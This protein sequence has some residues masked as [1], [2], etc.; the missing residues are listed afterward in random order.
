VFDYAV[1]AVLVVKRDRQQH[2]VYYVSHV[3]TGPELRYFLVEKFAYAL[4]IASCKLRPYFKSHH[5]TILTDQPLWS[6]LEKY[7]NSGRMVKWAIELAPYEISYELRRAI[8]AQALADFIAECSS[9]YHEN[10]Q[11]EEPAA[12]WMLYVDGSFISGGSGAGLIVV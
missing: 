2:L 7:G 4:L 5:I 8:K 6:T 11:I 3:L 10:D 1:S 12:A 9:P